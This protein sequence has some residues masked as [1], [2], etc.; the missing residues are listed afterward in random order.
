[1][2]YIAPENISDAVEAL[3]KAK[4]N[5]HLLAGGSDL[6][7]RMKGGFIE[8]DVIVDVKRIKAMGKIGK[9]D[10]GF[11]VGGAVSCA[12][13][14]EHAALRKAW[15]GVVEAAQLIGSDQIQGRCTVV[16]NVCNA[17]PAADSVPALI[18]ADAVAVIQG[19]KGE[20]R[21][22]VAKIAKAPGQTS[23][24]KK[25]MVEAIALPKRAA[26]SADAYLR[27]IP[28]TEMDIAVVS[29]AVNLSV[30]AKGVITHARVALGAVAP[31]AILVPAAAKA[32]IG[33]TLDDDAL[34]KLA[35]ACA[36]AC[37]P[38]DDKRGTVKFRTRVASVLGKRAAAI[39]YRRAGGK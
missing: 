1:M 38:I 10:G 30:G 16:G 39:A 32:L 8:P 6:L 23:L 35:S 2:Q 7:V 12:Q 24:K 29:A 18:A 36:D 26:R 28:R 11:V 9:S 22:A 15:P 27:F 31:T 21:V 5:V 3:A 25:E 13:M 33:S 37:S 20:R 4:G 34:E 17:S 19:P 14:G